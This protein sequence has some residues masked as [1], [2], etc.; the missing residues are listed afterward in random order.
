MDM[1][2]LNCNLA[3]K[4]D[5]VRFYTGNLNFSQSK[6]AKYFYSKYFGVKIL[7]KTE[8]SSIVAWEGSGLMWLHLV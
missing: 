5:H 7:Q 6:Q 1:L 8:R 4:W 2:Y 3:Y